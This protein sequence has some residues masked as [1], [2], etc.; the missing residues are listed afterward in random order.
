MME[1]AVK[2]A[3]LFTAVSTNAVRGKYI[4]RCSLLLSRNRCKLLL[5]L[6][7]LRATPTT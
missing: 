1:V 7:K 3:K 5:L 6:Q 2:L 4:S